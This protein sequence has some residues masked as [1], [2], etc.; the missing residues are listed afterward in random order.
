MVTIIY[1][2][3]YERFKHRKWP[4][5]EALISVMFVNY[6]NGTFLFFL[7]RDLSFIQRV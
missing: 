7:R 2:G 4:D 3:E 1:P 6:V 5:T